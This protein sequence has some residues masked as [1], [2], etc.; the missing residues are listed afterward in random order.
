MAENFDYEHYLDDEDKLA[1]LS[2]GEGGASKTK[3]QKIAF[4]LS[5][6]LKL[7]GNFVAYDFGNFSDTLMEKVE[8]PYNSDLIT[9]SGNKYTL[10]QNGKDVYHKLLGSLDHEE[11]T[12]AMDIADTLQRMSVEKIETLVYHLFP[13]TT[14]NSV[15]KLDIE[16]K[17]ELL[18][19][20]KRVKV[21]RNND[22]VTI[23][24]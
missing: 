16:K 6:A 9:T 24:V 14:D 10:T 4:L 23:E 5:K 7:D 13:E 17:I 3:I 18:K 19:K 15:I 21:T 11:K 1:I 8:S 2:I 22:N 20:D 12:I